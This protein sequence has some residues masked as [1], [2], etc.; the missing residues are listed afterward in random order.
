MIDKW[1]RLQQKSNVKWL[2]VFWKE[3]LAE[4]LK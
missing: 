3:E 1:T 2:K 4:W